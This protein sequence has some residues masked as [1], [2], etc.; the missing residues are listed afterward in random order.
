M[1]WENNE[2]S[3]TAVESPI[4]GS[5]AAFKREIAD[6]FGL[7]GAAAHNLQ[8]IASAIES[9]EQKVESSLDSHRLLREQSAS[10]A[11]DAQRAL[12]EVRQAAEEIRNARQETQ[13]LKDSVTQIA[14]DLTTLTEDLRSRIAALAVLGQ[15]MPRV[16]AVASYEDE[17]V[18][19]AV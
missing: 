2:G 13:A 10:A 8:T 5:I 3:N 11:L 19:E 9:A 1:D 18:A 6:G 14:G 16:S 15:A 4:E 7:I 12:A 17:A